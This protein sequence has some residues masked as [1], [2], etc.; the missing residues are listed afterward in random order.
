MG[1][2]GA[3]IIYPLRHYPF[4]LLWIFIGGAFYTI[5]AVIYIIKKPNL[6]KGFGFHE[7]FHILVLLGTASHFIAIYYLAVQPPST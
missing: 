2:I 5:G 4:I 3:L 6:F 7:L 1:W